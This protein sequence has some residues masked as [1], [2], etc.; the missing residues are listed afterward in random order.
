MCHYASVVVCF[1][2]AVPLLVS[3]VGLVF[4]YLF[5]FAVAGQQLFMVR[6][7]PERQQGA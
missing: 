7:H 2:E 4:F 5:I 1:I 6:S 3:V